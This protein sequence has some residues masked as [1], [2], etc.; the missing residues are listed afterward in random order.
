M[1]TVETELEKGSEGFQE[2]SNEKVLA[3]YVLGVCIIIII[4]SFS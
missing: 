3:N 1:Q 2:G 4:L